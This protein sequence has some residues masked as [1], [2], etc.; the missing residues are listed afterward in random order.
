[1]KRPGVAHIFKE[2]S[3]SVF[4]KKHFVADRYWESVIQKE[5]ILIKEKCEWYGLYQM[6]FDRFS[7]VGRAFVYVGI[8]KTP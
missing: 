6:L 4:L 5:R 8:Y 3:Y 7:N 2:T 1:M